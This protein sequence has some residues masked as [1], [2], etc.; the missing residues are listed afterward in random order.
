M[1]QLTVN[2]LGYKLKENK[3][4]VGFEY[5]IISRLTFKNNLYLAMKQK[6]ELLLD[7]QDDI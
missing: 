4:K 3:K 6:L 1:V 2:T 7:K 5:V